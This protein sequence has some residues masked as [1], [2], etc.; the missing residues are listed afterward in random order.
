MKNVT[1]YYNIQY[2]FI[3]V[4]DVN[5]YD[6]GQTMLFLRSFNLIQSFYRHEMHKLMVVLM[7][8]KWLHKIE[9]PLTIVF[10]LL[11]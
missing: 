9:G 5:S 2:Q 3:S 1:M 4:S 11:I 7:S 10:F 8:I 6:F